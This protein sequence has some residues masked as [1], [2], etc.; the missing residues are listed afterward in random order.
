M[1][2][3]P[4]LLT[5]AAIMLLA[6][7]SP[8]PDFVVVSSH[9]L[10]GRKAGILVAL[11]VAAGCVVWAMLAVFGLGLVIA[12]LSWLYWLVRLGGAAY[13][14]WMGARMLW[15]ARHPAQGEAPARPAARPLSAP[16]AL[17]AGFLVNMT[18]PKAVAFFGSLFVTVLPASAPGWVHCA[19]VGVVGVVSAGWFCVLAL[20]FSV[21]RVRGTYLRLRRPVDALMGAALVGL[22]AKLAVSR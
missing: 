2:F 10:G 21:P 13:L 11:G 20:L 22:G 4:H 1:E 19:T 14:L 9:A 5:L 17:R 16:Q 3:L 8:G 12:R 6:C 7:I 18:N 15:A